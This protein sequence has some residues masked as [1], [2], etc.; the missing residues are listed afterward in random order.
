[1]NIQLSPPSHAL[2]LGG[3]AQYATIS[4]RRPRFRPVRTTLG[5]LVSVEQGIARAA[6]ET[7]S[8]KK[9]RSVA[10]AMRRGAFFSL[11]R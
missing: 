5:A 1:V 11:F 2:L 3:C 9:L 4:E 10:T 6:Q 7:R 8:K